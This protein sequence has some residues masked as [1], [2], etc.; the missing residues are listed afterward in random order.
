ML[1]STL[2]DG[3]VSAV[4]V[5][6]KGARFLQTTVPLNPGNSGGP[7]FDG[8][9]RVVGINSLKRVRKVVGREVPL[10][11]INF[12]LDVEYL[13]ELLTDARKSLEA[14]E[15]A[16]VLAPPPA[17]ATAAMKQAVETRLKRLADDGYKALAPSDATNVTAKRVGPGQQRQLPVF[18]RTGGEYAVLV[19]SEGV[20]D[21]TAGVVNPNKAVV[22]PAA[23]VNLS[24]EL[25]FQANKEG[26]YTVV[27]EN[28]TDTTALVSITTLKKGT[29]VE[30]GV[31]PAAR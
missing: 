13:H 20:E 30:D 27:I 24:L 9:G 18:C 28:T 31:R 22:C 19:V 12:A 10:E 29:G 23:F 2:S 15:I 3:I 16:A 1:T 26:Q 5:P 4:A 6:L 17:E 21:I 14:S 25:K 8:D 7:L 11:A